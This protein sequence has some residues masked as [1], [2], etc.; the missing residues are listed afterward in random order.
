M[1]TTLIARGND[2]RVAI[3]SVNAAEFFVTMAASVTFFLAL[4]LGGWPIILGL[5]LGGVMAAPLGA[6]A[7]KR[8]PTKPF[9]V[10]VGL[11]VIAL[12]VRTLLGSL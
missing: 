1:A 7:C 4:G 10:G 3:G 8:L 11:L 5:A 6:W 12:S 9:M 2:M